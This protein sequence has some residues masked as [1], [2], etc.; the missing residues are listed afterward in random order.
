MTKF[1]IY[2]VTITLLT[3]PTVAYPTD[4]IHWDCPGDVQVS[5][6]FTAPWKVD[7]NYQ[8]PSGGAP[9]ADWL[10]SVRIDGRGINGLVKNRVTFR[11]VNQY[12]HLRAYLNGKPCQEKHPEQGQ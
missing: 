10:T 12:E 6:T 4:F 8:L 1:P 9:D 3:V 5:I 2:A 7:R 11:E